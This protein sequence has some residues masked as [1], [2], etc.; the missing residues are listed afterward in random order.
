MLA[1]AI[2]LTY[3]NRTSEHRLTF[4]IGNFISVR[5]GTLARLDG[6]FLHELLKGQTRLFVRVT[7]VENFIEQKL[8]KV[9]ETP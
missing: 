7:L 1:L 5:S 8:D 6:V 9:L 2:L 3:L 4:K